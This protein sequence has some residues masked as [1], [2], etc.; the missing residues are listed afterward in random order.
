M[1]QRSA[2]V[3]N[4]L[5][6][7]SCIFAQEKPK[8]VPEKPLAKQNLKAI[9]SV[10]GLAPEPKKVKFTKA[11]QIHVVPSRDSQDRTLGGTLLKYERGYDHPHERESKHQKQRQILSR[12]EELASQQAHI[13]AWGQLPDSI[14]LSILRLVSPGD[15]CA[16]AKTCRQLAR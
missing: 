1:L 9:Y 13:F 12:L 5:G 11:P 8:V 10:P 2:S 14:W 15:L 4:P 3:G 7:R 6:A 16:C